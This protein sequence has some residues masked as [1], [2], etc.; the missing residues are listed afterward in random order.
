MQ[1]QMIKQAEKSYGLDKVVA[2]HLCCFTVQ[3]H[4]DQKY[5]KA[6]TSNSCD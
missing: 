5:A 4:A 1:M 3:D 2:E 6:D